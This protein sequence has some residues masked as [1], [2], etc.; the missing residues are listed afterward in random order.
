MEVNGHLHAVATSW[1]EDWMGPRPQHG[2]V[3]KL[4][5]P[6]IEHLNNY[7][8]LTHAMLN[9]KAMA[10]Q[11]SC[12][13]HHGC[14]STATA[15]CPRMKPQRTVLGHPEALQGTQTVTTKFSWHT[16]HGCSEYDVPRTL[17][18]Y[19]ISSFPCSFSMAHE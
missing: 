15:G 14:Q 3:K 17:T 7:Q 2:Q 8:L 18:L 9:N 1:I 16:Q 10:Y 5:V 13:H 11:E 19:T 12:S 6:F 4:W